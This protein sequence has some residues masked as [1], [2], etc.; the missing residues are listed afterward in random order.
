[1]LDKI[2]LE[3]M[4][5]RLEAV[6]AFI[7]AILLSAAWFELRRKRAHARHERTESVMTTVLYQLGSAAL[8]MLIGAACLIAGSFH[9][10]AIFTTMSGAFLLCMLVCIALS[11]ARKSS[12]PVS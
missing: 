5:M 4:Q 2:S 10:A 8:A 12:D 7:V 3:I 6:V 11:P 9:G 1:M